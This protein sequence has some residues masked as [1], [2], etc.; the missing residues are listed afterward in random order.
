M[1][2]C[3]IMASLNDI[4]NNSIKK[5]ILTKRIHCCTKCYRDEQVLCDEENKDKPEHERMYVDLKSLPI[6]TYELQTVNNK[7]EKYCKRKNCQDCYKNDTYEM[8]AKCQKKHDKII[9]ESE[10][11]YTQIMNSKLGKYLDTKYENNKTFN[12]YLYHSCEKCLTDDIKHF[13][14]YNKDGFVYYSK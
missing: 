1:L 9:K 12:P 8:C 3:K 7:I 2:F 11:K 10:E 14:T 6:A 5:N 13:F 4:I